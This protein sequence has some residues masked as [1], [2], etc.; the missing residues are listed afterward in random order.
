MRPNDFTF[1]R[2][3]D[4]ITKLNCQLRYDKLVKLVKTVRETPE[5]KAELD[6]WEMDF[7]DDVVKFKTRV[8]G[9]EQIFF[10]NKQDTARS[11]GWN[12]S[13][14]DAKH[15]SSV[16]LK[17]W[18]IVFLPRESETSM[19]VN[20]E[21]IEIGRPMGFVVEDARMIRL[22]ET[23]GSPAGAFAQG[24]KQELQKG[25]VQMIVCL[26]P[27]DA[28]DTYD[29]IKRICCIENG[30]PSQVIKANTLKKNTKSV[31]TKVAI[32]MSCKLGG[33]V[34]GLNIPVCY[35]YASYFIREKIYF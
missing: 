12:N 9:Q 31:L 33:E 5:A 29:A 24:I 17:N 13:L 30:I 26:V 16:H 2:D 20:R 11:N 28:K 4:G 6:R 34:W 25:I 21:I 10:A 3:L 35:L 18:L 7:S 19:T 14:K 15:I 23:R 1:K 32:Q 22:Q 8:L 27:S